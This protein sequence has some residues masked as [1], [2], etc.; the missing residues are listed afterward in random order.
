[1][2]HYHKD[3][4]RNLQSTTLTDLNTCC[5]NKNK[6]EFQ[7]WELCHLIDNYHRCYRDNNGFNEICF[8]CEDIVGSYMTKYQQYCDDMEFQNTKMGELFIELF[9][10]ISVLEN[11]IVESKAQLEELKRSITK[12]DTI[13]PD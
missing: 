13:T 4:L 8:S 11:A 7:K 6:M 10:R 12:L 1:M 2:N 5:L 9:D 3:Y